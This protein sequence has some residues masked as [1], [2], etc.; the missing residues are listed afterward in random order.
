MSSTNITPY[1]PFGRVKITGQRLSFEGSVAFVG[2]SPDLRY[3][4][5]C[6]Q[7]KSQ[8]Q[9][10][11]SHG[12]R[13][14]RDLNLAAT[15]VYLNYHYRKLFC[16]S[17]GCIRVEAQDFVDPG[18]RVTR[19]LAHYIYELCKMLTVKEVARHLSLDWKTVKAIDK[20]CLERDF[21]ETD[22][23]ELRVLAIDEISLR[24]G[25]KFLTVVLDYDT[26]RIVWMGEGRSE[27]TLSE[28]FKGMSEEQRAGIEAFA[29]DMWDPYIKAV[30]TWCPHAK[31]VFDLFHVVKEFNKTIDKVRNKE[32]RKAS[33]EGKEVLKGSKYLLL[34][35]KKNFRKG[36]R[37]RL[38]E[39]LQ[40]NENIAT[41]Y[42][43][44]DMIKRI[45]KYK[46]RRWAEKRIDDWCELAVESEI[47]EAIQ[48]AHRIKRYSYGIINH[49]QYP[50]SSGCIEGTNNKLKVIK[51]RSYGF[52]DTGYFILKAKQAFPG[53]QLNGR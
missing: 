26:G 3:K 48:F 23:S 28:F 2:I 6:H 37:G 1:F 46:Y 15:N 17:C 19:R 13:Y 40:L 9:W 35:N 39:V 8:G 51:R 22:Y 29:M 50:I 27:S 33:Q 42:I 16:R 47:P 43:L 10:I 12:K 44:R 11:H 36:E 31:I 4:P 30:R 45:W 5:L 18:M 53:H 7:C 14:V 32:Y 24:K 25:Y 41:M 38:R 52:H 34:K 21:G 20:S 49:C